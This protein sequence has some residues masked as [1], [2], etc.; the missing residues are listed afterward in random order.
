MLPVTTSKVETA[1]LYAVSE[2]YFDVLGIPRS[3]AQ[4]PSVVISEEYW[5]RRFAGNP[6][7]LGKTV[8][9]N[10]IAVT[11]TAVAP[12]GFTGT[13]ISTP[14]FWVPARLEPSLEALYSDPALAPRP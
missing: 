1:V 10:G 2:N 14:A 7:I 8:R 3:F 12:R 5:Q 9:L 6:A 11:I 4:G 13:G